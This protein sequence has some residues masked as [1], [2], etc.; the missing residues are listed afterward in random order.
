PTIAS[1]STSPGTVSGGD[2]TKPKEPVE[3]VVAASDATMPATGEAGND[4]IS[5][6]PPVDAATNDSSQPPIASPVETP[7]PGTPNAV[8]PAATDPPAEEPPGLTP[9]EPMTESAADGGEPGPLAET[10]REFGALLEKTDEPASPLP[11]VEAASPPKPEVPGADE[12]EDKPGVRRTGPRVVEVDDRLN[13]LVKQIELD[14]VPLA[15]FLRIVSDFSTIPITLDA[16]ILPWMRV[17]PTTAVKLKAA[18]TTVA[19]VLKQGLEPLGLEYRIE[20][21]QLFITR[22]PKDE[23]GVREV[24]F[25]VKDLVGDDAGKLQQLGA[26][27]MDFVEPES[28]SSR[29]GVGT[30]TFRGT[31]LIIEQS[32]AVQFEILGFCEQLRVARGLETLGPFDAAMFRLETCGERAREKL[33][34]PIRL[35]YIR[36]APLQRIVDRIAETSKLHI[37]IDWRAL[38]EAGWSPDAEVRFS[39]ADQPVA[40]ALATL[41]EPMDLAYRI[42]DES[43]LQITTPSVVDSRLEVEFYRVAKPD[44]GGAKLVQSAR[45]A[46]GAANFRDAGGGGQLA[47]DESS[48]CLLACLS[49][50]HQMELQAWLAAQGKTETSAASAGTTTPTATAIPQATGESRIV[51]ASGRA[52]SD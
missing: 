36:P 6:V 15:N 7:E 2:Q 30:I 28:W 45:D 9:K 21:D 29:G 10:L 22:R 52:S 5:D 23:T 44:D 32:E 11:E 18:D 42:I 50:T 46:L 14:G 35:T 48:N 38:A 13:D 26:L 43:T 40:K 24:P 17:S 34:K 31:E 33:A 41:L 47:F 1:V 3:A 8:E 20:A 51:P 12:T 25:K 4:G 49:Q 16:D 37:L 19:E 39:V 27:V